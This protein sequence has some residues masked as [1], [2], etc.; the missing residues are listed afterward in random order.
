[1]FS[2]FT[3]TFPDGK[4]SEAGDLIQISLFEG[5]G[6]PNDFNLPREDVVDQYESLQDEPISLDPLQRVAGEI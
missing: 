1:M 6:C 3:L 2:G 4:L 5:E